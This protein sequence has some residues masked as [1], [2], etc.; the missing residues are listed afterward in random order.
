MKEKLNKQMPEAANV[1][2]PLQKLNLM[3]DFLFD[4]TTVD[5]EACKIILELSLGFKIREIKW[6]EGQKVIH[7]LPGKRGIRMDFYVIDEEGQI[8]DVEMQKRNEGNIPKRT[9][10]Y[11]A[12]LDAPL[13]ESGEKGFDD[14]NATYIVV[15]CNFDLYGYG[16]YR[17][18][19]E[20]CCNEVEGLAMG[21]ECRK[22]IL[23]TQGINENEVERSLV[24]FLHY[25]KDSSEENIPEG[26]DDRLRHLHEK[27]TKI[28]SSVQMGVTYMKMQERDRLIKDE[29]QKIG[30]KRINELNR[31]LIADNRME[32]LEKSVKDAA[33][34]KILLEEYEL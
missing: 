30:T 11:Q 24:D 28:K 10:F 13:L 9:R 31:K 23:N 16:K 6:K 29:G 27:I 19:F 22:I 12:L 7:N 17:Y 21:D 14:L 34:Q 18:T 32:D 20:N 1:L 3:D 2:E 33:Y 26:C 4:V 25:I 5:L 15:I 8:F